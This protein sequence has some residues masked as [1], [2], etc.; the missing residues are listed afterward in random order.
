LD[1]P[2]QRFGKLLLANPR[3]AAAAALVSALLPFFG[4]P[5]GW[6]SRVVVALVT[7]ENGPQQ[8][9]YVVMWALLAGVVVA[10][11][12]HPYLL[13]QMSLMVGLSWGGACVLRKL[14][15]WS[16]LIELLMC[17]GVVVVLL[18]HVVV[19]DVAHWW[20]TMLTDYLHQF[21]ATM[22]LPEE[23]VLQLNLDQVIQFATGFQVAFILLIGL[24]GLCLARWWHLSITRR[25]YLHQELYQVR[26]G[27]TATTLLAL[28]LLGGEVLAIAT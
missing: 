15:S 27:Y 17:V 6:F 23:S 22:A 20:K 7:L 10:V 26:V 4:V 3:Y 13:L 1:K 14:H 21:S 12:G 8:G 28:G 19:G 24:L 16:V 25:G 5:M 9:L 18:T 11:L 2:I